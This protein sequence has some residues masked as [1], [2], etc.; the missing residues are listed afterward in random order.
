[1]T[2]RVAWREWISP[3]MRLRPFEV[4]PLPTGTA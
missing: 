4:E 3:T 2:A 1:M